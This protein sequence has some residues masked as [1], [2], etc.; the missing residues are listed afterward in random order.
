MMASIQCRPSMLVV[1]LL[2]LLCGTS[3]GYWQEECGGDPPGG[4]ALPDK[5]PL[6]CEL[7]KLALEYA[8][9]LLNNR[10]LPQVHRALNLE[11]C[12]VSAP[13][14]LPKPNITRNVVIRDFSKK[15]RWTS[16]PRQLFVDPQSQNGEGSEANPFGSV[17]QARDFIRSL[18]TKN[19]PIIVWLRGGMH[20]LNE[21]FI[22]DAAKGDSGGDARSPIIYSSHPG[23]TAVLSGGV[24]LPKDLKWVPVKGN[25]GATAQMFRV[26]LPNFNFM[27]G[28]FVLPSTTPEGLP[29]TSVGE[30]LTRAR[31]PNC[32]DI[33][34]VNCYTLNA[35]GPTGN[36]N[37]PLTSAPK[38]V[39]VVNQH[40][41]WMTNGSTGMTTNNI[42]V[43]V[44]HSDVAWRC[45]RD[46]G[47][48]EYSQYRT[49]LCSSEVCR[50]DQ[51]HNVQYWGQ[52]VS[53]GF[54]FNNTATEQ[55]WAPAWTP[56]Q[57]GNVSGG[58][59]HMYHS[60]RWGGWQFALH[61][62]NDTDHSLQ[63][64]CDTLDANGRVLEKNVAC[65]KDGD[66][67]QQAVV[68]GGWQEGRGASIGGQYTL[69]GMNNSYFVENIKEELD[70]EREW[71]Y[72]ESEG[73][74]YLIPPAGVDINS[75]S[76]VATQLK[77]VLSFVGSIEKPM[78]NVGVHD[79]TIAHSAYTFL[80]PYEIPSGGDWSIH[81]GASVFADGAVNISVSS[82]VF[83]QVDGNG[84]FFSRYVRN[85]TISNNDFTRIGDSAILVVGAS[86]QG[87][88]D[89]SKNEQYPAYNT[90][91]GNHVDTVGVW[92]KQTAAYFKSVT[93]GNVLR[94]NVF[95]DGPRSGVNFNDGFGGGEIMSGN[96]LLN[97]VKE[98]N[99]HGPFNS[100]D[101][102]PY[103]YRIDEHDMSSKL[104]ISPQTHIIANNFVFNFNF[105]GQT[106]GSIAIDFDDE[107]SQMNVSSNLLVYGAIKTFDG[108]DRSI[109][110]NLIL[111][112]TN[113]NTHATSCCLAA[114][115]SNRNLSSAHTHFWDN[116]CVLPASSNAV[117]ECGAG[118]GPFTNKSYHIDTH[119]NKYYF[120]E[121][122][123]LPAWD[124][125]FGCFK[126]CDIKNF[127][128]WQ[129]RGLD[130]GST[131][132]LSFSDA[133]IIAGARRRIGLPKE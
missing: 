12:N 126:D 13:V 65:P 104:A 25:T 79:I 34:G 58:V 32:D 117:Y 30:R 132:S 21:T 84:I 93:R 4:W 6:D 92:G 88:I 26:E 57:W 36:P 66:S 29:P 24:P 123:T 37:A 78:K 121:Q 87:R 81:R 125:C 67:N 120:P 28:L 22:L 59:V 3:F 119:S 130:V 8:G 48:V 124:D 53:G 96:L 83:D 31:Y 20:Y 64:A 35:S 52:Q 41:Y 47:W 103:V 16:P 9:K 49:Q 10:G 108:M 11:L 133:Q 61:S 110:D 89:N 99:D 50:F 71:Y 68:R 54:Y 38:N 105:H 114:L 95:H 17:F 75:I 127:S 129:A 15:H 40:G 91:E 23:E 85:S 109:W 2:T 70:V 111:F 18:P 107:T 5:K 115:Q 80:D 43:E 94:N 44:E 56:R 122:T 112:A 113:A 86:G 46:C 74:L 62:R 51:T 45:P 73:A 27:R 97:Y 55:P 90:I 60:A 33:T 14:E 131:L 39:E 72:D 7:R 98:S 77:R 19:G 100:W 128:E 118:P 82:C 76:L 63:F 101:R 106:C 116:E 102:Q 69:K 42:T 1:F